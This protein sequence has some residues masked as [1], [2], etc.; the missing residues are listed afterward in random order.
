MWFLIGLGIGAIIGA[1]IL[2]SIAIADKRHR[3]KYYPA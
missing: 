1:A 2:I 3:A